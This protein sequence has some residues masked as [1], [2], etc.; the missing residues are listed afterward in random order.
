MKIKGAIDSIEKVD[1]K[2][3]YLNSIFDFLCGQISLLCYIND[4]LLNKNNKNV[5]DIKVEINYLNEKLEQEFNS[6][7]ISLNAI[8]SMQNDINKSFEEIKN[9]LKAK[10]N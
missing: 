8:N 10:L 9:K 5:L 7:G 3:R 4:L 2:K 1:N 6:V